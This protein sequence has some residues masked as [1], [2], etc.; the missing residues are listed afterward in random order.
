[1]SDYWPGLLLS[2]VVHS[3]LFA[4]LSRNWSFS[5][6]PEIRTPRYIKATLVEL[7]EKSAITPKVD[8]A[9]QRNRQAAAEKERQRLKR[10]EKV[11]REKKAQQQRIREEKAKEQKAKMEKLFAKL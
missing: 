11:E 8:S 7:E 10:K 3:L 9:E 1:M 2:I 5:P 6:A 4:L